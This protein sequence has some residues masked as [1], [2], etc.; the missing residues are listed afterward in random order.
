M[1]K[2]FISMLFPD[3]CL[4]CSQGLAS[5]ERQICMKCQH[6]LPFANHHL[7]QENP[8]YFKFIDKIPIQYALSYLKF[9]KKGKVQKMLHS[10]KY[11]GNQEIGEILGR[12]HGYVLKDAGF[13][14]IFDVIVPVPLHISKLKKRGYNQSDCYASGLSQTLELPWTDQALMRGI[15]TET[16][17]KKGKLER[18]LNVSDIFEV[19]EIA[20][21]KNKHVLL[22]DDVVTT[23]ST[24]ES[25][26]SILLEKGAKSISIGAIAVAQH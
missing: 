11:D 24:L 20:W 23:G 2:A 13:S 7:H 15:A 4:T 17:T 5:G 9:T 8:L 21:I 22:V 26:A 12:W 19:Q 10:L 3:V 18:W 14:T 16:Q 1:F 25:C 6:E